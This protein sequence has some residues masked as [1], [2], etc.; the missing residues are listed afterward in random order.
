M[1]RGIHR[2]TSSFTVGGGPARHRMYREHPHTIIP[3]EQIFP[4]PLSLRGGG[5]LPSKGGRAYGETRQLLR[6]NPHLPWDGEP[7]AKQQRD[8]PAKLCIEHHVV[9]PLF[10]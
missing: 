7:C 10:E 8:A 6:L 5:A 9:A 1:E 4:R 2:E 3:D